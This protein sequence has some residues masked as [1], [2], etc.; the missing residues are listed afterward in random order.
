[1]GYESASTDLGGESGFGAGGDEPYAKALAA[2]GRLVM[3]ADDR[4]GH[5]QEYDLARWSAAADRIDLSLFDD[6]DGPVIDLGC[7]PGRM[8]VAARALGLPALGIDLSKAAVRVARRAGA[9]VIRGSLFDP[10]PDEGRWDTA[11]LIDGNIGIGGDPEGL[12]RRAGEIVRP[13]GSVI[14]EADG[15]SDVDRRFTATITDGDGNISASFPWAVAGRRAVVRHAQ[16]AGLD[17]H[18]SW[19]AGGRTFCRLLAPMR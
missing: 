5:A 9:D 15:D 8:L 3:N 12:F 14:V 2:E 1:M 7:G 10:V 16:G 19:T 13:G 4:P 18:S 17:L 11:F 6:V